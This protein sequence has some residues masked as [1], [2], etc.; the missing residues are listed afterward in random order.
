MITFDQ[1]WGK[2]FFLIFP[3]LGYGWTAHHLSTSSWER[4]F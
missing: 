2:R 3:S 1:L 4:S